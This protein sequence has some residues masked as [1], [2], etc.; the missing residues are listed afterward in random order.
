MSRTLF[1]ND[2]ERRF[3]KQLHKELVQKI[4]GQEV[5]YFS[6]SVEHTKVDDLYNEA[7]QKTVFQPVVINAL[8]YYMEPLP[9]ANRFSLD[10]VYQIEAYFGK[11]EMEERNIIPR[12]G[13]F[14][15]FGDIFY[16]I[17]KLTEPQIYFGQIDHSVMWKAEARVAREGQ[18]KYLENSNV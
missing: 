17:I 5:T 10:M 7:V 15:K 9:E 3:F 11:A 6:V 12:N 2:K 1:V 18:F 4:V 16:E 13:D 14:L 8:V